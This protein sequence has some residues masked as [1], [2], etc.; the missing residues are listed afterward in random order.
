MSN[1][2][3]E[4]KA[5]RCPFCREPAPRGKGE[6]NKRMMKRI[7]ANDP[8]ALSHM[9]GECRDRGDYDAAFEYWTK[10]AELG[11]SEAHYQLASLYHDG[12]GVEKNMERKCT[13]WRKLRLA[14]IHTLDTILLVLRGEMATW[15]KL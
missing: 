6:A 4:V 10:A 5:K 14:V 13:I 15:K 3:D 2:H 11:D 12:R 9:G 8:A 1:R 7:K